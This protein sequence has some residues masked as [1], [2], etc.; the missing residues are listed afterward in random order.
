MRKIGICSGV[1]FNIN[2]DFKK[3]FEKMKIH[4]FDCVDLGF[5]NTAENDTSIYHKDKA[6]QKRI[7]SEMRSASEEMGIEIYQMHGPWRSPMRDGTVE[8][9]AEWS[10]YM[11][12]GIEFSGDLGCKHFIVHPIMPFGKAPEQDAKAFC[13]LNYEFYNNLLPTAKN[14]GVTICLENMP[15]L[16]HAISKAEQVYNFVKDM[17]SENFAMCLDTGHCTFWKDSP[18]DAVRKIGNTIKAFHVHDNDGVNDLHTYPFHGTIDWEDFKNALKGIDESVVLSLETSAYSIPE[19]DG[20]RD[21]YL[22]GLVKIARY[23]AE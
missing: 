15:F 2:S 18:A 10:E 1:Y 8:D 12:Q 6:E 9:R 19:R 7:I 3:A 13:E 11:K 23:L 22:S 21:H 17:N 5:A 4:G 20:I 16:M 14:A